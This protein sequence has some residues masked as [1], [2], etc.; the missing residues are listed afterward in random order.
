ML[1]YIGDDLKSDEV[2]ARRP[3]VTAQLRSNAGCEIGLLVN[4]KAA[5][6]RGSVSADGVYTYDVPAE[7]VRC[8]HNIF[9]VVPSGYQGG[10][11]RVAAARGDK[12]LVGN[13]RGLWRRFYQS[14]EGAEAIADGAYQLKD[15]VSAPHS[16]VALWH[17]LPGRGP[18]R[19]EVKAS[20]KLVEATDDRSAVIR[21]ADGAKVEI[22]AFLPGEVHLVFAGKS[23]KFDT[24]GD[25]HDYDVSVGS[26]AITVKADGKELLSA[27]LAADANDPANDMKGYV[28]S[29]S[30]INSR[31]VVI[32]SVSGPGK[33][34]MLFRNLEISQDALT[35]Q[36]FAVGIKFPKQKAK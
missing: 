22:V 35:L 27:S 36:D 7:L 12:L 33:G 11:K 30:G 15:T 32:G 21:V 9:T 24:T 34:T 29:I 3:E 31:G 25:F 5:K 26:G 17:P 16:A 4:G 23:A 8:G 20:V 19:I 13:L 6:Q 1:A 14:E 28:E 10:M 18:D 2:R